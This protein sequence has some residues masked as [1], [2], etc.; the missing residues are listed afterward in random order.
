MWAP[1][2]TLEEVLAP[3]Y[4]F[5]RYQVEAAACCLGGLYYNHTLR[6]DVQKDPEIVE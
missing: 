1:M 4:L 5:H 6:G 3:V 2:A